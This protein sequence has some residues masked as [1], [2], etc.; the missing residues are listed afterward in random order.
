MKTVRKKI[1]RG[2][3]IDVDQV[4]GKPTPPGGIKVR[5]LGTTDGYELKIIV[6]TDREI[7][8]AWKRGEYFD[9]A[10][11]STTCDDCGQVIKGEIHFGETNTEDDTKPFIPVWCDRC[12]KK[13]E[14]P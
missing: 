4:V 10:I 7:D 9:A 1:N 11:M 8:A 5:A 3:I 12:W 13:K 2:E 14:A 6:G